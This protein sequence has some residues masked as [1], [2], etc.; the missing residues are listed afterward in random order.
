MGNVAWQV[1]HI[2]S[3]DPG[4]AGEVFQ[5]GRGGKNLFASV[6][7]LVLV[8]LTKLAGELWVTARQD[9]LPDNT[10]CDGRTR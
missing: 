6:P 5:W 8:E 3:T 2:I 10:S 1:E 7:L 9:D 4:S